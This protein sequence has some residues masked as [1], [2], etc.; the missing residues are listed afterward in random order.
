MRISE[1]SGFTLI[2]LGLVLVILSLLASGLLS[3]ATQNVRVAKRNELEMKMDT[4]EAALINYRKEHGYLP[5]PGD[6]TLADSAQNFGFPA[7]PPG[8]CDGGDG[9]A[10][11]PTLNATYAD[12]DVRA[13]TVP[14]RVLGLTDEYA[15]DPWGGRFYYVVTASITAPGSFNPTTLTNSAFG[16]LQI[17]D[18]SAS[19]LTGNAVMVLLSFGP[20]GRGAVQRSGQVK[21]NGTPSGDENDN[22]NCDGSTVHTVD[23]GFRSHRTNDGD[24]DD[25]IRYY[26]RTQLM[27]AADSTTDK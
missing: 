6:I 27:S 15:Y 22:C 9:S 8:N 17:W 5:C 19:E 2:E 26:T 4:I 20:N 3:M 14:V 18:E 23:N 25:I 7:V 21:Y 11:N 12:A 10:L 1:K 24:F 13:G 16:D